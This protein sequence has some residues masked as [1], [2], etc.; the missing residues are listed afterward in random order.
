MY[1]SAKSSSGVST[2]DVVEGWGL[3]DSFAGELLC[4]FKG[5]IRVGFHPVFPHLGLNP[6]P[7]GN[8]LPPVAKV[9]P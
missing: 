9:F 6:P 5:P 4:L 7:F 1:A 2:C 8:K 3:V